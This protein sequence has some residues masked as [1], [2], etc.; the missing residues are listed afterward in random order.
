MLT[1]GC[2]I[3]GVLSQFNES[4]ID[5]VIQVTRENKFPSP[6]FEIKEWNYPEQYGYTKEQTSAVWDDIVKDPHFWERLLAYPD[7]IKFLW[8]LEEFCIKYGACDVYFITSRPGLK[9]KHQTERWLRAHG[10][11][12]FDPTVLISSEKGLC[13]RALKLDFYLDD[14]NEN[15]DD[16]MNHYPMTKGFMLARPWNRQ[17]YGV[18]RLEKLND[19]LKEVKNAAKVAE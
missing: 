8:D 14:R 3:D 6:P 16:V 7:T 2:D 18:P 9:A 17:I 10:W 19:F 11:F 15:C 12:R 1:I 4:F 5:R 13:A